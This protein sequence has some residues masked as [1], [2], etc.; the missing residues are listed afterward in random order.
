MFFLPHTINLDQIGR[1]GRGEWLCE[2]CADP[3]K[4]PEFL[5]MELL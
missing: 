5:K 3:L 4:P 2:R 1:H